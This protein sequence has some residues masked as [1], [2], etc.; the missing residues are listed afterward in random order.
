MPVKIPQS[1]R[2]IL[3]D[4]AY[5]ARRDIQRSGQA[6]DHDGLDGRRG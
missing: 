3:E 4:K 1:L 2:T 5:G 6:G